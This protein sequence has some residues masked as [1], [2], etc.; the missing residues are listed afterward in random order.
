MAAAPASGELRRRLEAGEVLIGT[1]AN[2]GSPVAVEALALAGLDWVVLD[3]EHGAG[4]EDALVG[5]L[6]AAAAGG[7]AAIVRVEGAAGAR[8]GRALD[9]GADGVM[10]PRLDGAAAA[11]R[12]IAT[13]RY[14]PGGERGV[15]TYNRACGFG[16]RRDAIESAADRL[17]GV[18]QIES[19]EAV[20]EAGAIARL[21]GVQALFIGPQDLSYALG[22]PGELAHPEFRAAVAAVCEAAASAGKVA[23]TL[24]ASEDGIDGAL[25]DG[26]RMIAVGSDSSF[27]VQRAQAALAA[28]DGRRRG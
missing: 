14:P 2:L 8:V 9:L 15:A 11:E 13:M 21:E 16:T 3:L 26:F 23:G 12:A 22:I 25:D 4:H 6:H 5:Q 17:L 18:V 20:A 27:L 7:I 24:I 28:A 19:R 1:F 10:F